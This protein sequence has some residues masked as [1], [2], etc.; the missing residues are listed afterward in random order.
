MHPQNGRFEIFVTQAGTWWPID[1][2]LVKGRTD[3]IIEPFKGG[4][5]YETGENGS[6]YQ[7][8]EVLVAEPGRRL[9]ISWQLSGEWEFNPK[10][11]SEVEVTFAAEGKRTRVTLTHRDFENMGPKV[12][13]AY[14]AISSDNG[15]TTIFASYAKLA[16]RDKFFSR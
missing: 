10:V 14:G 4:R 7:W 13:E 3:V 5:W 11:G 1:H 2:S 16:S 15:W 12:L 8:G 9:L 6:E